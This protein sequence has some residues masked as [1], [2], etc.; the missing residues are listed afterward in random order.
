[1]A[2]ADHI[3]L[4]KMEDEIMPIMGVRKNLMDK[5]DIL[6]KPNKDKRFAITPEVH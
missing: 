1:M 4:K 5:L 6:N 2:Q 3:G